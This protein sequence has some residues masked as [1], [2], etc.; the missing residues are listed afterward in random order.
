MK[1]N[2]FEFVFMLGEWPD[3]EA[4]VSKVVVRVGGM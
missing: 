4:R 1:D 2:R 3:E